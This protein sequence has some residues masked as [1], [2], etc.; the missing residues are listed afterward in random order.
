MQTTGV[1]QLEEQRS[2]KP[3]VAGSSPVTCATT[4]AN[5]KDTALSRDYRD[6]R[7]GHRNQFM[8]GFKPG[9]VKKLRKDGHKHARRRAKQALGN[10]QEPDPIYP[11]ETVYF[12]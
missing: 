8:V 10:Q 1:A 2:P 7:G 12:D 6:K 11:E 3:C 9:T 5:G 4:G